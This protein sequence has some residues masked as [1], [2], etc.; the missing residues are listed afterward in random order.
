MLFNTQAFISTFIILVLL[1]LLYLGFMFASYHK[2]FPL[3][4]LGLL[5]ALASVATLVAHVV[6]LILGW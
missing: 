2:W 1:F 4:A 6:A 3:R 5:V